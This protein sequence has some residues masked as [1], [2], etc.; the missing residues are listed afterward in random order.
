MATL[1]ILISTFIVAWATWYLLNLFDIEAFV[2]SPFGQETYEI[3]TLQRLAN[4]I[5]PRQSRCSLLGR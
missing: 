1:G 5:R 4:R 2:L 3:D